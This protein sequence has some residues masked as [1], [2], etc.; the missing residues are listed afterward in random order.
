M[1]VSNPIDFTDEQLAAVTFNE[2]GLVPAI[3]QEESTGQGFERRCEDRRAPAATTL[4]LALAEEQQRAEVDP[5]RETRE[6]DRR[7][8][9]C[10]TG[11]EDPLVVGG[12][13]GEKPI[14]D[15]QVD[16]RIAEELEPFVVAGCVVG[17]FVQPARVD[18]RL[19]DEV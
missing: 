18:E 15:R 6:T 14:G 19:G 9:R 10:A 12:M 4:G 8:D 16:D 2:D 11:A 3:V 7:H 17:M 5:V 13:G 1:P